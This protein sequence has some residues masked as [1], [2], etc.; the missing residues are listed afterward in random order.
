M[1]ER[2]LKIEDS[3]IGKTFKALIRSNGTVVLL[4]AP[5][6]DEIKDSNPPCSV[7]KV[8]RC[9]ASEDTYQTHMPDT[10]FLKIQGNQTDVQEAFGASFGNADDYQEI[11][12]CIDESFEKMKQEIS[13]NGNETVGAL[14]LLPPP[15][16]RFGL[17][18]R[19]IIDYPKPYIDDLLLAVQAIYGMHAIVYG[20]SSLR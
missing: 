1:V 19:T 14:I 18:P 20:I 15:V 6:N 7:L 16:T 17:H 13:P 9:D 12:T 4:D 5:L 11:K 3:T 10:L 2:V 8:S